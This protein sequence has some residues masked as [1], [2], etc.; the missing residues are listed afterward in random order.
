M[1]L[2]QE[3]ASFEGHANPI[4]HVS[5]SENGYQ[6]ATTSSEAVK[7]WDLRK[8][9]NLETLT[10]FKGE[11]LPGLLLR[12]AALLRLVGLRQTPAEWVALVWP[13]V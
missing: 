10:P 3:V 7:L 8:L 13:F 1:S 4:R 6:M 12:L 5:F 9:R 2:L 11:R